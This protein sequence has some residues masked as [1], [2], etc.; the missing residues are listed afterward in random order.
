MDFKRNNLDLASS[1]YLQ[2][3]KDNLVHWQEWSNPVIE[4]AKKNNKILFVS[5][6]YSTCHWCH[7]MAKE[8][9]SDKSIADFLNKHFVS[10][11]IDREQRP[12]IDQ[13]MMSFIQETQGQG[14]WPLNVFFDSN[15]NPFF[16][17]TYAPI[18]SLLQILEQVKNY[19]GKTATFKPISSIN[20]STEH[21]NILNAIKASY[22]SVNHGFNFQPKFPPHNT[23]LYLLHSG[24][25]PTSVQNILET[26]SKKGLHDHLQGGFYRYCV[27]EK[28]SIP[29]FEKMLYDQAMLLWNYSL[30]YKDYKK[31]HLKITANKIIKCLEET[32]LSDNLFYSA[33]D[34]DT[35]HE[36]GATYI[37]TLDEIKK[38]LS[39]EEF[40]TFEKTYDL[41]PFE[42]KFHLIKKTNESIKD[43]EEKLLEV[44][45]TRPQ[46]F[47]DKKIITSWNCLTGIGLLHAHRYLDN[48]KALSLA[49]NLFDELLDKHLIKG[50][51]VHS[52]LNGKT[53]SGK[54]LEDYASFLLFATYI[55]EETGKHKEAVGDFI[56][57]VEEF[58]VGNW[59]ESDSS[60][61]KKIAASDI[62]QP[63]PSSIS[64]ANLAILRAK[65][66]TNQEYETINYKIPISHDFN[67]IAALTS[68]GET[69][70]IHAEEKLDWEQL[71]LGT[72]QVKSKEISDCY[73]GSCKE[74]KSIKELLASVN[75]E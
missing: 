58:K 49:T 53:Q 46:P 13:F 45:N 17:M 73:K 41:I 62:D 61:F 38:A 25:E 36:E 69:H 29:H 1:P 10:I 9:F 8:A 4:Y 57:K 50:D 39:P 23:L 32:F 52:S 67:N 44:R 60:D 70:I 43:I 72:I 14:G 7:V 5:S 42:N 74:F 20:E 68:N 47:I 31:E 6:G 37:W 30:A 34:A 40:K 21:S 28:W 59:I 56:E 11:K 64:L 15:T 75:K 33:H 71:P 66:L 24:E 2:Q 18:P 35:L 12:D 54:F 19:S 26:M 16:A 65:I 48:D 55:F 3:H 51:L 27:D 22:D 63:T